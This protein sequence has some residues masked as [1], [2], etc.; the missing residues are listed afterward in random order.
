MRLCSPKRLWLA[1]LLLSVAA[2]S[3]R[4]Q[5][6]IVVPNAVAPWPVGFQ[7]VRGVV[8]AMTFKD[9][10]LWAGFSNLGWS[11]DSGQ[12]WTTTN[13]PIDTVLW[14]TVADISF[15]NRD[16]GIV[17]TSSG[18]Y[19]TENRGV[20]WKLISSDFSFRVIFY[21][22]TVLYEDFGDVAISTDGGQN[23]NKPYMG[24][25]GG[26]Q[27]LS[28]GR[29]GTIYTLSSN[30]NYTMN[31]PGWGPALI[32]KDGGQTWQSTDGLVD[33]DSYSIEIDSCNAPYLYVTNENYWQWTHIDKPHISRIF[34]SSDFGSSWQEPFSELSCISG[35]FSS[36]KNAQYAG[37]R[38]GGILR[39]TD[40]GSTW[41]NIG[42]PMS[43]EDSRT[44]VAA[45][46]NLIFALDSNGSI[47]ETFN[48]GGDSVRP[49]ILFSASPDTLFTFDSISC[50]N[51]KRT[52]QFVRG[53]CTPPSVL[54]WSITGLDSSS[55]QASGLSNDSISVTLNGIKQGSQHAQLV[56]TL[57][58]GTSDT[59]A[60]G[61]YV[62][63]P[64]NTLA[65]SPATLFSSDTIACDSLTRSVVFNRSGCS[66]PSIS[67]FAI[68]GAD[69]ASFK[70]SNLSY[71]SILVTLYGI[72]SGKQ[73][74]QLVL[75]LNN[76]SRDTV[77][78]IGD[79]MFPANVLNASPSTL[80]SSDTTLCDS[81]TKSAL[82]MRS[83]CSPPSVANYAI[84]GQ[85]S[86]AF[87]VNNLYPDSI[88]VTLSGAK[89]GNQQ[90]ELV[91]VLDNGSSD[92]IQL[93]GYVGLFHSDLSMTTPNVHTDTLGATVAVPITINGLERAENVDLI[94]HYD[95]SVNYL[96]SFSPTGVR[97]DIPGDSSRGRSVLSISGATSGAVLGYAKFNV[98]NDSSQAAH[99]TFDS[100]TVLTQTSPCEYSMPAPVTS[101]ITTLSGCSIPILSQ[102]I[103]LGVEP[104]FSIVPN[105]TTGSVWISSNTDVGDV[106]I[107]V[108]DVLGEER[109][110]TK[111]SIQSVVPIE[112]A[113]PEAD[114]VFN[115][116][117][118]SSLGT[119]TL[120]AV[121]TH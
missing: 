78:L 42:G 110:V 60:L 70:A 85:D 117:V 94:L 12:T 49:A 99:A 61:G 113:L 95:G 67:S 11:S 68:V 37:T 2:G 65:A 46:D 73:N 4:G 14:G 114:G 62:T 118:R 98:F 86:S 93:A 109:S 25:Y 23:W 79:V 72:K 20:T 28:V 35:G 69:S 121:R 100:I 15:L 55:F 80:F 43:I 58:N 44:I 52:V 39:S 50:D 13:L 38:T 91:L 106:T 66:P 16:T 57:D 111:S 26:G 24:F 115:I 64:P 77:D 103:H 51:I 75:S 41:T 119:R 104:A 9:G 84:V 5:W 45:S 1:L 10:I 32:S 19:L 120:R 8:G 48:S 53:S 3:A 112:L 17:A 47:W 71:D 18:V 63:I 34:V 36:S 22:P 59:V 82:F 107:E 83:G 108:Y 116:L 33:F 7:G 6:R 89:I 96:G 101:T 105:P 27:G 30:L 31:P 21:S 97:L 88:S 56:L 87:T 76:G 92:T 74:A 29:D 54:G 40:R 81:I 90:A 102:L